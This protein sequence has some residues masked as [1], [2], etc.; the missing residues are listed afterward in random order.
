MQNISQFQRLCQV[1]QS[2]SYR[3]YQEKPL[4]YWILP[5]D[6][7]LPLAFLSRNLGE[8][9]RTPFEE[10]AKTPGIGRKKMMALVKLLARAA[11][12]EP[13]ELGAI[14]ATPIAAAE[15]LSGPTSSSA[16]NSAKGTPLDQRDSNDG[17][18]PAGV[19]EIHW[20]RW[21]A[22][23]L[24]FRLDGEKLG[25]FAPSLKRVTARYMEHAA[26]RLRR[27]YAG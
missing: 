14:D 27:L 11:E 1:L 2:P 3:S 23:V 6:R 26:G 8:L 22:S 17:F 19:S 12:T 24:R 20:L 10:L 21:R 15:R 18:D 4:A 13:A 16:A 7:R 25:R 5:I 9:V